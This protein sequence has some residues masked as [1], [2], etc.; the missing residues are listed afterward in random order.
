[1]RRTISVALGV[2]ALLRAGAVSAGPGDLDDT[3]DDDGIAHLPAEG[4]PN[5]VFGI[6]AAAG[7][8]VWVVGQNGS[9]GVLDAF[10]AR[11]DEEGAWQPLNDSAIRVFT[12]GGGSREAASAVVDL[13]DGTILVGGLTYVPADDGRSAGAFAFAR[14]SA[15]DATVDTTFGQSGAVQLAPHPAYRDHVLED[16]TVLNDGRIL[17][18]GSACDNDDETLCDVVV[19]RLLPDATLDP[20]F[21]TQG[22]FTTPMYARSS[23]L[24]RPSMARDAEGNLFVLSLVL[25]TEMTALSL[26]VTKLDA[27]GGVSDSYGSDGRFIGNFGHPESMGSGLA[28]DAEGRVVVGGTRESGAGSRGAI[29]RVTQSGQLDTSFGDGGVFLTKFGRT[30]VWITG[31]DIDVDSH[32]QVVFTATLFHFTAGQNGGLLGILRLDDAGAADDAGFCPSGRSGFPGTGET[33]RLLLRNGDQPVLAVNHF[34]IPG[35]DVSAPT[36]FRFQGGLGSTD[37]TVE[38][39]ESVDGAGGGEGEGEG[40]G[41]EEGVGHDG[42][43]GEGRAESASGCRAGGAPL[44]SLV[45][46][47]FAAVAFGGRRRAKATPL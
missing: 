36:L 46:A 47:V 35:G 3:F 25:N 22:L 37:C 42:A 14:L 30:D 33:L 2:V 6:G 44:L 29:L 9:S 7:G 26:V 34:V 24:L 27:D 40:E 41:E 43:G 39:D 45:W 38:V 28:V 31:A 32:G 21:G 18:V 20:T 1:M 23:G 5:A 10:V 12:F 13:G 11:F 15:A 19:A 4:E 17:A 8:G 16:F